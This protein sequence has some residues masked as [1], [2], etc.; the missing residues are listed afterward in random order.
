[1]K[2]LLPIKM[3]ESQK[4]KFP[5]LASQLGHFHLARISLR[6][7]F[8]QRSGAITRRKLAWFSGALLAVSGEH[9]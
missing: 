4:G 7:H 6:F 3:A 2:T 8:P 1:M 5:D 9:Q